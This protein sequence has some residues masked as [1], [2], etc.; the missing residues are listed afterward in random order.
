MYVLRVNWAV[1]LHYADPF[2]LSALAEVRVPL[3]RLGVEN[4]NQESPD[5]SSVNNAVRR[6]IE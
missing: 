1:A 3:L 5:S 6:F 4:D 2:V